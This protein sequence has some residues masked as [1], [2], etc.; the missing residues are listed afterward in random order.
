VEPEGHIVDSGTWIGA[1]APRW[2]WGRAFEAETFEIG[3]R[4]DEEAYCRMRVSAP[5]E[6]R[7][8]SIVHER[9]RNG[10]NP[11][12]RPTRRSDPAPADQ[13]VPTGFYPATDHPTRVRY[14]GEWPDVES[15]ETDCAVGEPRG[16]ERPR[17]RRT[18]S[19]RA[20]RWRRVRR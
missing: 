11:P 3:R 4:K 5:D 18:P 1:S 12:T 13:V 10:A 2:A 14:G 7:V 9:H 17:R 20:T 8:G 15:V 19:A 16:R 6:E